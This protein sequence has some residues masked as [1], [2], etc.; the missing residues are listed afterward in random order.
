VG[1][2]VDTDD[3]RWFEFVER[4]IPE[5]FP[6]D[7]PWLAGAEEWAE[8]AGG[9]SEMN[10]VRAAQWLEH[11]RQARNTKPPARCP[12]IFVSHRQADAAAALRLAWLAQDE[13]WGYWLDIIDLASAPR[14]LAA[15]T[16]WLGRAPTPL[17][18]S[19][20][21]AALIEMGLL[22]CSHVI[23]AMT[24]N[25]KGSQWVPYEYGRLKEVALVAR[26]A[27]S[28]WD[29]TTLQVG[30]LPEYLHLAPVLDDETEIRRWLQ[31]EM[32]AAQTTHYPNC[33]GRRRNDW[34]ERIP[35]PGPLPT[36]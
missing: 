16:R 21:T 1:E 36:G 20:F 9:L 22:N 10:P 19:I 11:I 17:Q 8:G 2:A 28:W 13:G 5:R 26:N 27:A 15:L 35:T 23:A 30:D 12:R 6:R 18:L 34:P 3:Y 7:W 24:D 31:A 32:S 29:T 33:P 25:T 14:Q 4:P